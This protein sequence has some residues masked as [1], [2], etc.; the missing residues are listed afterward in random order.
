MHVLLL[1]KNLNQNPETMKRSGFFAASF[2]ILLVMLLTACD[3]L[4]GKRDGDYYIVDVTGAV[5]VNNYSRAA[6]ELFGILSDEESDTTSIA[7][8]KGDLLY[9]WQMD[10]DEVV[11]YRFDTADGDLLSFGSDSNLNI[12]TLNDE[13]ISIYLTESKE[14]WAWI[15]QTEPSL[16]TGIRSLSIELPL[17]DGGL[18]SLGKIADMN[19]G[20]GLHLTGNG[21]VEEILGM[22]SPEWIYSEDIHFDCLLNETGLNLGNTELLVYSCGDSGGLAF[23]GAFT[24]LESLLLGDCNAG[25]IKGIDSE[26]INGLDSLTI[27]S[28]DIG[29][30]GIWESLQGM[31]DLDLVECE[32]IVS[33]GPLAGL[34]NLRGLGLCGCE[35]IQDYS[36]LAGI[37]GLERLSLG[38]EIGQEELV[39]I[40]GAQTELEFLELYECDSTCDLSM[41]EGLKELKM[42]I[43]GFEGYDISR[44]EGLTGLDL[45]VL[46]QEYYND[47]LAILNLKKALPG[48]KVVPGGTLCLGTGWLLLLF[49]AL[50]IWALIRKRRS[51]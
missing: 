6:T 19:P 37:E 41:L 14:E 1:K 49:P 8:K 39:S 15:E 40:I 31:Q 34:E 4:S 35:D 43:V 42:L 2:T 23:M 21:P 11:L 9:V 25:A 22:F 47:S 12:S 20:I 5:M 46:E 16:F 38:A 7:A 50:L 3:Q 45:L 18:E 36:M 33:I 27:Y 51:S 13:I 48:T 44:L 30:T 17:P 26:L 10:F 24:G 32:N 28:S 29:N